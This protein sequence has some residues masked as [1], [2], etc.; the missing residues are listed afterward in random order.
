M[1]IVIGLG[2]G[3]TKLQY[4]QPGPPPPTG[5]GQVIPSYILTEDG[6]FVLTETNGKIQEETQ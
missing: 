6:D 5:G 4:F 3:T 1:S 2:L